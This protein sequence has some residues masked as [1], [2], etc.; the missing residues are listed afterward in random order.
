M[1]IV[2]AT[3]GAAPNVLYWLNLMHY[4]LTIVLLLALAPF[5]CQQKGEQNQPA[6]SGPDKP[7]ALLRSLSPY[8]IE[9]LIDVNEEVDLRQVWQ[10]LK[11][12]A[13]PDLPYRCGPDCSAETFD[14]VSGEQAGAK[15]VALRIA[16]D[17]GAHYQYLLF[18]EPGRDSAE[19]GWDMLG[20][21]SARGSRFDPPAHRIEAG[22]NRTWLVIK[23]LRSSSPATA[24]SNEAWYDLKVTGLKPVLS[25]PA[26]GE[27]KPC[28]EALGRSFKTII[29]RHELENGVYTIPIQ[30]LV[31]YNISDCEKGKLS[32]GLFAKGRMAYYVWEASRERFILD[33]ARS[34]ITE[35]EI[36]SLTSGEMPS[37]AQFAESNYD[38]LMT[39]ARGN[40]KKQRGW[41]QRFLLTVEDGPR[42]MALRQALEIS[43]RAQ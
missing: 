8:V 19:R 34:E 28:R 9:W 23:D 6:A 32:H 16:F 27:H 13:P 10:S 15:I 25:F 33:K 43:E 11:L 35:R 2:N 12:D 38:E 1:S 40:D 17:D 18:K 20:A 37:G 3:C 22:D 29:V 21:V 24:H 5:P 7:A 42:K 26:R 30:F 31:S 39:I 14:V 36:L 4:V 41:L